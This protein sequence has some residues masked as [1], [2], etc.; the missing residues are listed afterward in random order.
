MQSA[1]VRKDAVMLHDPMRTHSRA[2]VVG[3]C[4]AALGLL[5]F[6][7]WGIL[8][9]KPQA[10]TKDGIVIGKPSGQV[11]V[12]IAQP[13]KK[14][15]PVFNMASARLLLMAQQQKDT[16]GGDSQPAANQQA[17]PVEVVAPTVVDDNEL[18]DIPKGRKV[19]I[20]DGP[21]LLPSADQRI[22]SRWTVCDQYILDRGLPDPA[23]ENK[24]ETTVIAGVKELG[25]QLKPNESLLV[26]APNGKTYL[27]YRTPGTANL[28]NTSAVRAEVNIE[29]DA[30]AAALELEGVEPRTITTGMLNAIPEKAPLRPPGITGRETDSNVDLENPE[31]REVGSVFEVERA[32][33][34]TRTYVLLKNGIE[35]IKRSTANL[36][37]YYRNLGGERIAAVSPALIA[38]V[39]QSS[40][41]DD[42]TFPE[43][44]TE[45][46]DP[47]NFPVA[48]LG[49]SYSGA[50]DNAEEF[51]SVHVGKA[52]PGIKLNRDGSP[53]T[54]PISSPNADGVRI[55]HF[56]MPAGRGAVVRQSTSPEDFQRGQI[57]L[58][59][60]R[61]VKYGVPDRATAEGLGLSDQK[62]A[63][64]SIIQLLPDG[65]SLSVKD[66]EQSYDSTPIGPGQY[67]SDTPDA[68]G[69]G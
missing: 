67:P 46:L 53:Q 19:G 32:G 2:T 12:L 39:E 9:P 60:D 28:P 26:R 25:P 44:D 43:R 41:I 14:L 66:V 5:G 22:E 35:E 58:I 4:I 31:L 61:G 21:D 65:A 11:Y 62:P 6:L 17:A 36:I 54:V 64:R 13:D 8:S 68:Q 63:P 34:V 24:V 1:L 18:R 27:V 45:V 52:L 47:E 7:I 57:T 50:G 48:C 20:A 42:S 30:V 69:G 10:P 23:K 56:Y 38:N 59:S 40:D 16:P 33:D 15:L 51:T 37:R 3:V 55:D 49:W 29:D